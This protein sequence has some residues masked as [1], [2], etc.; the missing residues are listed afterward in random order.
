MPII[1]TNDYDVYLDISSEFNIVFANL[2]GPDL[3]DI[4]QYVSNLSIA[5]DD[6]ILLLWCAVNPMTFNEST[7]LQLNKFYHSIKNPM[8]IFTGALDIDPKFLDF[9]CIGI[10]LFQHITKISQPQSRYRSIVLKKS[11]KYLFMSTKD[12]LSRRYILQHL[13]NYGFRDQ[14]IIAYKCLQTSFSENFGQNYKYIKNACDSINNQIPIVGFDGPL[15]DYME[16]PETIIND[17]YLSIITET[18][19][20]GPLFFS[21][22]IYYAMLYNHFFI[23]LGPQHSLKYLRS[24]GF[25]TFGHIINESYDDIEDPAERLFAVTQAIDDFLKISLDKLHQLYIKN[26]DI[27]NTNRQLVGT[28]DINKIVNSALYVAKSI[29]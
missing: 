2:E 27:I 17:T 24:I 28:I 9:H 21:E 14:G 1:N 12:Y 5:A 16:V 11:K 20:L 29:R 26:I 23:Y 19:Y 13:L 3:D 22:K 25:K 15:Y 10:N 18:Y 6:S 7:I 4:D 8:V